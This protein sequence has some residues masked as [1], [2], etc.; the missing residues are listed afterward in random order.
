MQPLIIDDFLPDIY[1]DSLKTLLLGPE[2]G[3]IFAPYSV[4]QG[5][6]SKYYH[7]DEPFKEHIQFRH[8]FVYDGEIQS[9]FFKF[10]VPLLASFESTTGKKIKSM[11]RIKANLLM[12]QSGTP[13]QQ[14]HTDGM[15][16]DTGEHPASGKTTLLYYVDTSDGD[17]VLYN[18]YFKGE[19][20]GLLTKQQSVTPVKGR[21]IIFDSDQLHA[22][23]C[24]V[25]SDYRLVINCVLDV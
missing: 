3:W 25:N 10:I 1:Q 14:P 6:T 16:F 15:N 21:A 22:G 5:D 12:P 17:T 23:S 11:H 19:P 9:P 7:I 2:I 4:T 18:E 13:V 20:V 24:P 8:I